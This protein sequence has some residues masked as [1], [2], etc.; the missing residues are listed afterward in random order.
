ML[1]SFFHKALRAWQY[2]QY[3]AHIQIPIRKEYLRWAVLQYSLNILVLDEVFMLAILL[4]R[5]RMHIKLYPNS[6]H[7]PDSH[8]MKL[9]D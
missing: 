6:G 1:V 2:R 9:C 7:H 5:E 8:H 4:I 3:L